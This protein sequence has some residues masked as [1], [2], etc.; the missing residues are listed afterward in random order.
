MIMKKRFTLAL[1]L[2]LV[3]FGVHASDLIGSWKIVY[4]AQFPS[5]FGM[6]KG[7][8]AVLPGDE[9]IDLLTQVIFGENSGELVFGGGQ[10]IKFFYTPKQEGPTAAVLIQPKGMEDTT[11]Y[12]T[13]LPD[14]RLFVEYAWSRKDGG[15]TNMIAI[16]ERQ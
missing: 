8:A 15:S 14:D 9:S 13:V 7:V 2:I 1:V 11:W 10:R 5:L 16:I 6:Q 3:S 12:Y 4:F